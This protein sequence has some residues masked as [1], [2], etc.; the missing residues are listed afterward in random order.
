MNTLDDLDLW[1]IANP[2]LKAINTYELMIN[3][4]LKSFT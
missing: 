1:V 2:H 3:Y 4:F